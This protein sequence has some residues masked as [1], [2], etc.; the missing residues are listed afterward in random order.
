MKVVPLRTT[1]PEEGPSSSSTAD[2]EEIDDKYNSNFT[3]RCNVTTVFELR[4][5]QNKKTFDD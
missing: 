1:D 4:R 2:E 3:R 5:G